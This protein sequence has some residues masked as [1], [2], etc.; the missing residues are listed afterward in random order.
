M[1]IKNCK[2]VFQCP[3]NW[4]NLEITEFPSQCLCKVCNQL[5]FMATAESEVQE[6]AKQGKCVAL[7]NADDF[8]A[9]GVI[10]AMDND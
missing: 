7:F 4:D 8:L 10:E 1:D 2:F 3:Q 5:V 9:A 6:I